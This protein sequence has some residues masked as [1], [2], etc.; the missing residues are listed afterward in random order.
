MNKNLQKISMMLVLAFLVAVLASVPALAASE[1]RMVTKQGGYVTV[2][3]V[4]KEIKFTDEGAG[5]GNT[6]WVAHAPVVISIHGDDAHPNI[7]YRPQARL[8][9]DSFDIGEPFEAIKLTDKTAT[10]TKPGYYAVNVRFGSE[11]SSST[12][13]EFVVQVEGEAA[14]EAKPETPTATQP[15]TLPAAP[16]ASKVLVN[17]NEVSFEAYNINGNN[18]FKLRDLAAAVNR[19]G[20]QFEVGWDGSNNA[21]ALESGKAYTPAGGELAVSSQATSQEALS[22][23]SKIYLNG[24]ET[25]FIAY[26]IG[27]NNYFKLR[28]IAKAFNIG[29]TWEATS[30]TVGIDTKLD[31]KEE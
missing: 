7:S 9:K 14:G 31:Y 17:G 11:F 18:Y 12:V 26:N 27:G 19:T 28:D 30:N 23:S 2:S 29:V 16:T 4:E 22:T 8:V 24:K 10:L 13:A 5:V 21:I 1:K 25:P 3:N 20:K 15:E 6:I